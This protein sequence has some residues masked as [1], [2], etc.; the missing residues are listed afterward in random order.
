MTAT[1]IF[2]EAKLQ[3]PV[4][5]ELGGVSCKE[6]TEPKAIEMGSKLPT[7]GVVAAIAFEP[8]IEVERARARKVERILFIH[9]V[10]R[11]I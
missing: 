1:P 6:E 5:S 10:Y 3:V 11:R 4:E 2:E 9:R 7:L 8:R